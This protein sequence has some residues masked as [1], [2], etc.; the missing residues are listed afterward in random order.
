MTVSQSRSVL[1]LYSGIG[2]MDLGARMAGLSVRAI[3]DVDHEALDCAS[4]ALAAI[5]ILGRVQDLSP[6]DVTAAAQIK[7]PTSALLVGGPPCTGFSHAGF[8][9]EGKRNATDHR[10]HCVSHFLAY[11]RALRPRAFVLENVPGLLFRNY[12]PILNRF[13]HGSQ[14]IG[15]S[16]ALQVLN[17]ADYGVPQAR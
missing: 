8:W 16:V 2:G 4:G 10:V 5:P 6:D 13:L 12:R 15:Y 1:S 17:A 14:A 11:V 7:A 3:V 9:I